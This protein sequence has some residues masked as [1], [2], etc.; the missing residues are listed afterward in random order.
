MLYFGY[1][2]T[3]Q[4][5]FYSFFSYFRVKF[6]FVCFRFHYFLKL[7]LQALWLQHEMDNEDINETVAH[8]VQIK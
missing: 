7:R 5:L 6:L 8:W 1:G 4:F 3:F 2:Q